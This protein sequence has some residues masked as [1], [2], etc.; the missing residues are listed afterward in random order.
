MRIN[1]LEL[2]ILMHSR[3]G[4]LEV[5]R[6]TV[7]SVPSLVFSNLAHVVVALGSHLHGTRMPDNGGVA[8]SFCPNILQH[9]VQSVTAAGREEW[10]WLS[11]VA[12][13]D[14]MGMSWYEKTDYRRCNEVGQVETN[15]QGCKP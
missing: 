11:T 10:L 15:T 5:V 2:Q 7:H 4:L 13:G 3:K 9:P 6:E 14:G 8:E 1:L 12:F